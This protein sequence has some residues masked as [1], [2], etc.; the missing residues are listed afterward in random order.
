MVS[1]PKMEWEHCPEDE[2]K[3]FLEEMHYMSDHLR[4]EPKIPAMDKKLI[5]NIAPNGATISHFDN[6][7]IPDEPEKIMEDV[8]AC[9]EAGAAVWHTHVRVDGI[10]S[11]S[12]NN[13]LQ[14]FD[15]VAKYC[16]DLIYSFTA[17][18]DFKYQDRRLF[19]PLLS[20][21][22]KARGKQYCEM[23]LLSPVTYS[24]GNFFYQPCTE[25]AAIDQVKVCQE[26]GLK[27]EIQTRNLDHMARFKRFF[28]DSGIME[29]PYVMNCCAGTHDSLPTGNGFDGYI[30]TIMLLKSMMEMAGEQLCCGMVAAERNWLPI[31]VLGIMLGVSSVRI[32]AEEPVYMYPHKDDFIDDNLAVVNKIK[33]IANELG[34]EIANPAEARAMMGIEPPTWC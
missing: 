20:D 25:P 4:T 33:N 24:C 31:T 11:H 13:Y 1:I 5:I 22:L 26:N 12:F 10:R 3:F 18:A 9:Y 27:P 23:V 17:L 8:I 21:M 30:N 34:R 15:T 6:P 19:E 16:P 2:V 32:G 29:P 14:C 7:Y 28:I